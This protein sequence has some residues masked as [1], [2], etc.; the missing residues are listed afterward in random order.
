MPR[1]FLRCTT[2]NQWDWFSEPRAHRCKPAWRVWIGDHHDPDDPDDGIE[3]RADD[4][5][6]AAARACE[7]WDAD[8]HY[9]LDYESELCVVRPETD[10]SGRA[11][12][13]RVEAEAVVE[14]RGQVLED[15][16]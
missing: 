14:Y 5:E 16:S 1:E 11:T 2:C 3:A 8:E 6:D 9:M 10:R 12:R 7:E 13:V 4:A 15:E